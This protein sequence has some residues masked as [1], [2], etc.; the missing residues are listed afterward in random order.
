M[1][2]VLHE[3]L[4]PYECFPSQSIEDLLLGNN[5]HAPRL[6]HVLYVLCANSTL[7][8]RDITQNV[9]EV[10]NKLFNYSYLV[11]PW[12]DSEFMTSFTWQAVID[13]HNLKTDGVAYC[14]IPVST[15]KQ[16]IN[17]RRSTI[18]IMKFVQDVIGRGVS[19]PS[20]QWFLSNYTQE[21][22]KLTPE[23]SA[24]KYACNII[25]DAAYI[26]KVRLCDTCADRMQML[27]LATETRA[28]THPPGIEGDIG[29][30]F[31]NCLS[32]TR[33]E[34]GYSLTDEQ[35]LL[36]DNMLAYYV[37]RELL[38]TDD[39]RT[40]VDNDMGMMDP[41]DPTIS[42][43]VMLEYRSDSASS[44]LFMYT[45]YKWH[46]SLENKC[47][48][49]SNH[50]VT[51]ASSSNTVIGMIF[52]TVSCEVDA[53][54]WRRTAIKVG[55]DPLRVIIPSSVN[56]LT[57]MLENV[58]RHGVFMVDPII[59]ILRYDQITRSIAV[60]FSQYTFLGI[61]IADSDVGSLNNMHYINLLSRLSLN[62]LHVKSQTHPYH[63]SPPTL[64]G[65]IHP[66]HHGYNRTSLRS[67]WSLPPAPTMYH[68][69]NIVD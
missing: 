27:R 17:I 7:S 59:V 32:K 10:A 61:I 65:Y 41:S 68:T 47:E 6:M 22:A 53:H 64:S 28:C 63:V 12:E 40:P 5:E 48:F 46:E 24:C 4:L 35:S 54:R 37:H 44:I 31:N 26:T 36:I 55:V 33:T 3:A 21:T 23:C 29:F 9:A 16:Y 66:L 62:P 2:L 30:T 19:L 18:K 67:P 43:M 13:I 39:E 45:M 38:L 49:D 11:A 25:D 20:L 69:V 52:V 50:S 56:Q 8:G 15:Y 58:T 42:F 1:A 14:H 57:H 34:L 60:S 51:E